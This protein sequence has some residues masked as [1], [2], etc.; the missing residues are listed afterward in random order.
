MLEKS[1]N[2]ALTM[3]DIAK[4]DDRPNLSSCI[5]ASHFMTRND[6]VPEPS[7]LTIHNGNKINQIY[8]KPE[9]SSPVRKLTA[10]LEN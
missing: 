9:L 3:R 2:I 10:Q 7:P 5:K 8:K 4:P 6:I 1:E